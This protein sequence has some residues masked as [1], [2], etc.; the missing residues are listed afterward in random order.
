MRACRMCLCPLSPLHRPIGR[1]NTPQL[2]SRLRPCR[3]ALLCQDQAATTATPQ[4]R[5]VYRSRHHSPGLCCRPQLFQKHHQTTQCS[6]SRCQGGS[7]P[8]GMAS[9][10][11]LVS[12]SGRCL[13]LVRWWEGWALASAAMWVRVSAKVSRHTQ[14]LP[15]TSQASTSEKN[16][17]LY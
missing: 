6:G 9:V 17:S 7:Q 5:C 2:C 15:L 13:H 3:R 14:L 1:C 11:R 4:D 12:V 16:H 10:Q 8:K